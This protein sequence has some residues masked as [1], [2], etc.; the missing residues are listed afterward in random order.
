MLKIAAHMQLLHREIKKGVAGS[1]E[2]VEPGKKTKEEEEGGEEEEE[3][4]EEDKEEEMDKKK[5][6]GGWGKA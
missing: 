3:E 5:K 6:E 4:E 1:W 2:T